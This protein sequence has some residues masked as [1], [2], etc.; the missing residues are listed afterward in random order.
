METKTAEETT[1]RIPKPLRLSN[2]EYADDFAM[3]ESVTSN[4]TVSRKP[5][6]PMKD[7]PRNE[8]IYIDY[9]L[10]GGIN[11][12]CDVK[13][14]CEEKKVLVLINVCKQWFNGEKK[15]LW[16]EFVYPL[17]CNF[18][19][20][21]CQWVQVYDDNFD[22]TRHSGLTDTS[23]TGPSVDNTYA[24]ETGYY[25]YIE[26]SYPRN[27][28]EIAR[29]ISPIIS[30]DSGCSM[31]FYYHMYGTDI[32][33]LKV[34][35]K[36]YGSM[37][38]EQVWDQPGAQGNVW[39]ETTVNFYNMQPFQVLIE[40]SCGD[41][42]YGDIAIDD[43]SFSEGCYKGVEGKIRL[44]DSNSLNEGRIEIFH[45]NVW[46]TICG[47][48]ETWQDETDGLVVCRQLGYQSAAASP[49]LPAD[50]SVPVHL[51]N[52]RCEGTE[53][54]LTDCRNNGWNVSHLYCS[55]HLDDVTVKCTDMAPPIC[56][57]GYFTCANQNCVVPQQLCDYNDDCGDYSDEEPSLC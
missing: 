32:N 5:N 19:E 23:L 35:T 22:W 45:D 24:N 30:Q 50:D 47:Y 3:E 38:V 49:P 33:T 29:L 56:H 48:N 27:E 8:S 16:G 43:I 39:L 54:L 36:E 57:E 41:G 42:V 31:T 2:F 34:F 20:S 52:I 4:N 14:K 40:A 13:F 25:V 53:E 6:I 28:D 37:A 15:T 10:V 21:F 26:T 12:P 51:D 18:E 46:G 1:K 7:I 9:K 44:I 11:V 55:F 17:A